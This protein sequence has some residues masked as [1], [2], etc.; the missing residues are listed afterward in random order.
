MT[1]SETRMIVS[2]R[3][4]EYSLVYFVNIIVDGTMPKC[5]VAPLG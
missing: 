4:R 2:E 5:D 1:L 3:H